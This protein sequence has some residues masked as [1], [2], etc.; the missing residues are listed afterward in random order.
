MSEGFFKSFK[1]IFFIYISLLAAD[2]VA[3]NAN[4]RVDVK[5]YS[6]SS[7]QSMYR[8]QNMV[9]DEDGYVWIATW[10]GLEKFDGYDFHKYKSYP[11]DETRLQHNRIQNIN[12][13][14]RHGIWC[15]TYD[16]R[17]YLFDSEKETF[18]DPFSFHQDI[19]RCNEIKSFFQLDDGIVWISDDNGNFWRINGENYAKENGIEHFSNLFP[20]GKMQIN[21]IY[22]DATGG[23]WI[24]SD[25]GYWVYG[26][27][28][29]SG[30]RHFIKAIDVGSKLLL[31]DDKGILVEYD[32]SEGLTDVKLDGLIV[33][34]RG[35]A[36]KIDDNSCILSTKEGLLLYD[37]STGEKQAIPIEGIQPYSFSV[38]YKTRS[39]LQDDGL[40]MLTDKEVFRINLN[41]KSV[42][43]MSVP[44]GATDQ[45]VCFAVEDSRGELW[46]APLYGS[47]CHYNRE[48]DA[49]EKAYYYQDG[50]KTTP[51][52]ILLTYMIDNQNNIWGRDEWGFNKITFPTGQSDFL[53][54]SDYETRSL[55]IDKNGRVWNGTKNGDISIY[56]NEGV[57]TG[58]FNPQTGHIDKNPATRFPSN[59]YALTEDKKGRIWIGTREDGLFLA[60]PTSSESFKLQR[61]SYNKDKARSINCNSIYSIFEDK[62]GRIWIGTYGG[63]I[64][65]VNENEG[66][67]EFLNNNNG[68]IQYSFDNAR[69]KKVRHITETSEGIIMVGTTEGL[70]TFASDFEDPTDIK[71]YRNWCDLSKKS[72]LSSNDIF[73][74]F[75][76]SRHQIYVIAH[77]GGICKLNGNNL[78]SD[79]LTFSYIGTREGLPT[80]MVYAISEDKTGKLWISL[81]NAICSYSPRTNTIDTYD[82]HTFHLPLTLSEAPFLKTSDDIAYFPTLNGTLKVDLKNLTKSN[83]VPKIIF[84]HA[85]ISSENDSIKVIIINDG[86]L[87]LKKDERNFTISFIAFDYDNTE[88]I[89]YAYRMD[90]DDKWL[91]IGHLHAPAFHGL[92]GGDH[93]LEVRSTNGDG[94][95]MDNVAT[96]HIHIEKTFME[97]IWVW[98]LSVL[99]IIAFGLAIWFIVTFIHRLR[100]QVSVEQELT[101]L[102]L[103]F[104]TDVS[105]ELR[106]PLTLIVNPI[107]E[108][109]A[110]PTLS[111]KGKDYIRIAKNNTDRMLKLINQLLDI[112]KIQNNKMHIYVEY[113]DIMPLFNRI[114]EDFTSIANQKHID[115]SLKMSMD[116]FWMYTDIDKLEKIVFNLLSNAFKYTPDGEKIELEVRSEG[117]AIVVIVSD[118]GA[119]IDRQRLNNI[120]D[121]FDTAGR[122]NGSNSS[123]IGLSLVQELVGILHGTL[124]V[125]SIPNE[126]SRFEVRLPGNISALQGNPN[127]EFILA[128]S[129]R[130]DSDD[131][132]NDYTP[133]DPHSSTNESPEQR[134]DERAS[135]LIVEDNN[136][137]RHL[138]YQM[139]CDRY[140]VISASD[141]VEA[142][143]KLGEELPQMIISDIM[144]PRMDGLELLARVRETPECSHIPFILLSAKA[145]IRDRIE[146]I[147][148]GADDYIT[149]P[150]SASYLRSRVKSLLNQRTRLRDYFLNSK[151]SSEILQSE[152][153]NDNLLPVLTRFDEKFISDLRSLIK[154]KLG[155]SE[156]TIEEMADAMNLGR[157]VFNKK[158]KSLFAMS[159]VELLKSM[160]VKF[161]ME[162]LQNSDMTVAE[163]SYMCGFSSPQ[164][165]NRVFK[166]V[167]GV[168]PNDWR[169]QKPQ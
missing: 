122:K 41:K 57:L 153:E 49:L 85:S 114:Y 87:N 97:T 22:S 23:E 30:M 15:E 40:W 61:F 142:W 26:K 47:L 7:S 14:F 72:T 66:E 117:D 16:R 111:E 51:P 32:P 24:L 168:T 18:F 71:F 165:F 120:F 143:E 35:D 77:G 76:D 109:M 31:V 112:R 2:M 119:G 45:N 125:D 89:S 130:K 84:D 59:V 126:G 90:G 88:N 103:R 158:V 107:E 21:G 134:S 17:L 5:N 139:L 161:A 13:A 144:M 11:T 54:F 150:F 152:D 9:Q 155:N 50:H 12:V 160:R 44:G 10:N 56:D 38:L 91:E 52:S 148:C 138:M 132:T 104:F 81:E 101:K 19:L 140:N 29:L 110:D 62:K 127:V 37:A 167:A 69:C 60:T 113:S 131:H 93:I 105:H 68:G 163:I 39:K 36:I 123:G 159:P 135:I 34:S 115:F 67:I 94:V 42:K 164:Y 124:S 65:L 55:L 78:L 106:T 141:G 92:P 80:D 100:R 70:V 58:Y 128:D 145:S 156:L 46:V 75:E 25:K 1:Y 149:K 157:T 43:K 48:K 64:N 133:D 82:W 20:K 166:G 99:L 33:E 151:Q 53:S 146:G 137:L 169:R 86:K 6:N 102:K 3:A 147:E 154:E 136:E 83:F 108:V 73:F 74:T 4:G 95:W 8:I 28:G 118:T 63:G 98:I 129:N 96:L 162:L 27:K 121:R 116:S 79:D